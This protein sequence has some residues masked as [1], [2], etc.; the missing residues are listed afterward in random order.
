[1]RRSSEVGMLLIALCAISW[2][3][4]SPSL[5]FSY[6]LNIFGN[7]NMDDAIDELD[8]AYL[9]D[10]IA[11]RSPA[12]EMADANLDGIVDEKD[13][14]QVKGLID[15]TGEQISL[16]ACTI[17]EEAVNVTIPMP[18]EGIVVLN[19]ACA[20]SVRGI[21]A[22]DMVV[23]V[24]SSLVE[25]PNRDFFPEMA[26]LPT[27]GKWSEPDIEA[28]ISLNPDIVIADLRTPDPEKL[29]DKLEGTGI[30]VVRM[31]FT[32]PDYSSSEIMALGY[33]LDRKDDARE[34]N[35]F[36]GKYSDLIEER[37]SSIA[38]SERPR[39]YPIYYTSADLWKTGSNGSIVDMLCGLAG[40]ENIAHDLTGGTGGMYP[41]VDPEWV[42]GE[43]PQI[44]F[45]W[46]SPGGYSLANDTAM[47]ELWT[48]IVQAPELSRV[49][50]AKDERV[51]LMTTEITS[52]PRWFVGLSYLAK[53]FYPEKF[54]DLDPEAIHKEYLERFQGL[55]YQGIFVYP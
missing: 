37:V 41:T 51:H 11:G 8:I 10:V 49:D 16:K 45:T 55:E 5:A 18:V 33:I 40:G 1:M 6:T 53:W 9:E 52:R 24:G 25:G 44:I 46:S 7:A 14:E 35:S 13:I 28:I 32:Y 2:A 19:L 50:A 31:G 4:S 3:I 21:N 15:G 29:E 48:K 39:V 54:L 23:G 30:T 20:E 27:V 22:Q 42:V 47:R 12:T 26:G 36:A 34:L 17:Y 38:E 43:N